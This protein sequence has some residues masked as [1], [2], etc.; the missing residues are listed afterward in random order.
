MKLLKEICRGSLL[1]V[2]NIM[3]GVSGGTL[4]ISMGIYDKI[5][6]AV[7]HLRKD[8][9][10][11]IRILAPIGVGVLLG[12]IGLSYIIRWLFMFYPLQTNLLFIGLV[13]GGLPE[14]VKPI[15]REK[16]TAVRILVCLLFFSLVSV[17]PLL[18]ISGKEAVMDFSFLTGAKM[19]GIGI[20][21][22]ATMVVPGVSGSMILL[23]LGYYQPLLDEITGCINGLLLMDG[24]RILRGI[25]LLGP[26]V[27]GVG[28]GIIVIAKLVEYLLGHHKITSYWAILG[29]ILASPIG[30]FLEMETPSWDI[31]PVLTG[32]LALGLGLFVTNRLGEK[33]TEE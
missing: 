16:I 10:N 33:D 22:A 23:I 20:I 30:I 1:G 21:S 28:V 12:F 15:R 31:L 8:P 17:L 9:K 29:L 27:I 4:A 25:I 18:N 26:A 7:T 6:Y 19:F 3:P 24:N 2:A 14:I 13:L 5:I 11:S 32:I